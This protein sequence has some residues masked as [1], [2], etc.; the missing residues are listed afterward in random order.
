MDTDP[1]LA[2]S[3]E[4]YSLEAYVLGHDHYQIELL[5]NL[6]QVPEAERS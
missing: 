1:G 5:T 3:R 2:T 4:D 6:D